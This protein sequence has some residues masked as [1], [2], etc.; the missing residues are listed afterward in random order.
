MNS[1]SFYILKNAS[2][3]KQTGNV[4]PQ[5]VEMSANYPYKSV[6]SCWNLTH[7]KF[8]D[9]VPNLNAFKLD[10][11]AKVT[12][13]VSVGSIYFGFLMNQKMM[14]VLQKYKLP[15][16]QFYPAYLEHKQQTFNS[17]YFFHSVGFFDSDIDFQ[18]T[19]F[20]VWDRFDYRMNLNVDS[21]ESLK[22]FI[23]SDKFKH[24]WVLKTNKYIFI[25]NKVPDLDLFRISFSDP[26]TYISHR[27]K[28]AL[29]E[30]NI[31]GIEIVPTD[32]I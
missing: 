10:K 17:F 16:N 27:L 4:Y 13:V 12:D 24:N 28:T 23:Q 18:K 3:T 29:E 31:T 15:Q 8:P 22:K 2:G 25:D 20:Y 19:E 9:F 26:R 1:T 30:A 6:E 7:D 5:S 11:R 14:S 21:A 32:V